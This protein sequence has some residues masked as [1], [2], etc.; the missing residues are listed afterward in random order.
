MRQ[1]EFIGG[2]GQAGAFLAGLL[3]PGHDLHAAL[4]APVSTDADYDRVC[5]EA[6]RA[7]NQT[8]VDF[9]YVL[10][11]DEGLFRITEG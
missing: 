3:G 4:V 9:V 7:L 1:A 2:Y 5:R 6:V 10:D 8:A 11:P